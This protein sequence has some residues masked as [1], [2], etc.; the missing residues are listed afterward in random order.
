MSFIPM[1]VANMEV[2]VA[3]RVEDRELRK[4]KIVMT[5][6]KNHDKN[7]QLL[8]RNMFLLFQS[9]LEPQEMTY[10]FTAEEILSMF[11]DHNDS[12]CVNFLQ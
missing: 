3:F 5:N 1:A 8:D 6:K 2:E 4:T 10:L 12:L 9:I 7:R 11:E